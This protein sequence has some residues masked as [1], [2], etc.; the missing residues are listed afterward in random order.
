MQAFARDGDENLRIQGNSCLIRSDQ[1]G[2]ARKRWL[3]APK[4][5]TVGS[6]PN[7]RDSRCCEFMQAADHDHALAA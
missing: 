7:L 2:F 4:A 1:A 6:C 3:I 5:C